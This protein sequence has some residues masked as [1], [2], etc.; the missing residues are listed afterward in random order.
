MLR[1]LILYFGETKQEECAIDL[2]CDLPNRQE[3]SATFW[4]N[5][6]W[7]CASLLSLKLLVITVCV[8]LLCVCSIIWFSC[9]NQSFFR[10]CLS[11]IKFH[12]L[13]CSFPFYQP[14]KKNSLITILMFNSTIVMSSF[15][16]CLNG[17]N[18]WWRP[19]FN[20]QKSL[21]EPTVPIGVISA[22][23]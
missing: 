17:I 19:D 18:L 8:H 9:F 12:L 13:S 21:S 20:R 23:K 2:Y 22:I 7:F 11:L 10:A 4:N 15:S 14:T 16:H 3:L 5:L 1:G 6:N